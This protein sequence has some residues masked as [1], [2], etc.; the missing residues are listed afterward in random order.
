MIIYELVVFHKTILKQIYELGINP[1]DYKYVDLYCEYI[2]MMNKGDKVSYIVLVLAKKHKV[3]E[4][5]VYYLLR[6]F[7]H[8]IDYCKRSSP[9]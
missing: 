7:S 9:L 3:S 2:D 6:K 4:R 5:Q 1:S 8:E